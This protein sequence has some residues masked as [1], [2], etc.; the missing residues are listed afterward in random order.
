MRIILLDGETN[1][2]LGEVETKAKDF[3]PG[4]RGHT[5][6]GKITIAGKKHQVGG[7]LVEIGSKP[8]K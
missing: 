4:S 3:S 6:N 2:V 5:I 8:K 1:A 7:N